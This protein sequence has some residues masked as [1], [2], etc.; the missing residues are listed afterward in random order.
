MLKKWF[1]AIPDSLC[2]QRMR[3]ASDCGR[4]L[5]DRPCTHKAIVRRGPSVLLG[6]LQIVARVLPTL[7]GCSQGVEVLNN[8]QCPFVAPFGWAASPDRSA[9]P[10]RF[11]S[12]SH[13]MRRM[14]PSNAAF[15]ERSDKGISSAQ[16]CSAPPPRS[17]FAVHLWPTPT[18]CIRTLT[19]V[20]SSV[21]PRCSC[22]V[23]HAF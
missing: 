1:G 2:E 10:R 7:P 16:L 6:P 9:S 4:T 8:W 22:L 23:L 11:D 15:F 17:G 5:G 20:P 13:T 19:A 18:R 3:Y 12:C 21:P 14:P